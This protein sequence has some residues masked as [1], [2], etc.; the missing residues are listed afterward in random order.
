MAL[1]WAVEPLALMLPEAQLVDV[2]L[3]ADVA[4]GACVV[5]LLSA[6]LPPPL[7]E[8]AASE[9]APARSPAIAPA[10]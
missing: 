5:V 3:L 2:V 8:Q 1:A 7:E 4:P 6:L 10:R 9:I